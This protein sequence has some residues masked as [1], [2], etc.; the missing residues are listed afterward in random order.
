MTSRWRFTFSPRTRQT[1]TSLS[2]IHRRVE[3]AVTIRWCILQLSR[4][5]LVVSVLLVSELTMENSLSTLSHTNVVALWKASEPSAKSLECK[6]KEFNFIIQWLINIFSR[7]AHGIRRTLKARPVIW[8]TC[9]KRKR[10]FRF[11]TYRTSFSLVSASHPPFS[12]SSY[13]PKYYAT[14]RLNFS[15]NY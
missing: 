2:A 12:S 10:V 14:K 9:C 8:S 11:R 13:C 4:F 6:E 5:R 7:T 1:A 3:F 15:N